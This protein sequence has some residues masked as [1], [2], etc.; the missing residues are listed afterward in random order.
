MNAFETEEVKKYWEEISDLPPRYLKAVTVV[1]R[2]LDSKGGCSSILVPWSKSP[3]KNITVRT[4]SLDV[5]RH[6]RKLMPGQ[7]TTDALAII[8]ALGHDISKLPGRLTW[9]NYTQIMH[10]R[11]S[12]EIVNDLLRGILKPRELDLVVKAVNHHHDNE[13]TFNLLTNLKKADERARNDAL[14]ALGT[15]P[16]RVTEGEFF[17]PKGNISFETA[18]SQQQPKQRQPEDERNDEHVDRRVPDPFAVALPWFDVT[19]FLK[20]LSSKVNAREQFR[21]H[22]LAVSMPNDTCYFTPDVIFATLQELATRADLALE[23]AGKERRWRIGLEFIEINPERR[24]DAIAYVGA[25]LRK[26]DALSDHLLRGPSYYTRDF[27][28]RFYGSSDL[29]YA[30][31]MPIKARFLYPKRGG[32][33]ALEK[34]KGWLFQDVMRIEPNFGKWRVQS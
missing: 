22:P 11:K 26:I 29:Q 25:E 5:A 21:W 24:D 2:E 10:A 6:V 9:W 4:H 31:Y 14:A 16:H 3:L 33:M 19:T 23:S 12:A 15:T 34:R 27:V 30:I 28:V 1:L 13:V 7:M 18:V 20:M 32:L 8:A 17:Y